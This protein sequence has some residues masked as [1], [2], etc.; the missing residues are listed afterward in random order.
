MTLDELIFPRQLERDFIRLR[1]ASYEEDLI[2]AGRRHG[3]YLLG[4]IEFGLG[5]ERTSVGEGYRARLFRHRLGNLGDPVP[6][7][8]NIY[9][10]DG[11]EMQNLL[12]EYSG[13]ISQVRQAA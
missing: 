10:A 13:I 7:I 1:T 3:D 5:R 4:K 12:V 11:I 6:D 8:D 9:A 2:E